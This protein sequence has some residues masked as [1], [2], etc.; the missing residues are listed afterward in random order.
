VKKAAV[1][2]IVWFAYPIVFIIGQEGLRLWS[3][4]YD[5]ILFTCLDLIAKVLY[6]LWAVSM[7]KT[8]DQARDALAGSGARLASER[9]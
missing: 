8:T 7:V 4:L 1:L 2:S 5:A 3:P 9:Y 6:G